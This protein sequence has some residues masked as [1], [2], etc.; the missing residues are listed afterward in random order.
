MK[1][2]GH[3]D[4]IEIITRQ[5][6]MRSFFK[7]GFYN[8]NFDESNKDTDSRRTDKYH[9]C[10]G[11]RIV[12]LTV[13]FHKRFYFII[14][15]AA[16]DQFSPLPFHRCRNPIRIDIRYIDKQEYCEDQRGKKSDAKSYVNAVEKRDRRIEI[17]LTSVHRD[18]NKYDG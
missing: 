9:D 8:R 1:A 12:H 4:R 16:E 18:I 13:L 2:F 17:S 7:E 15:S 11:E 5:V 14:R 10:L 3:D 6:M